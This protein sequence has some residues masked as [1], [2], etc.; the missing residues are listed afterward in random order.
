MKRIVFLI[1]AICCFSCKNVYNELIPNNEQSIVSFG[2]SSEDYQTRSIS[3]DIKHD[4]ITV[5]VPTGTD[6]TR[7]LVQ[8]KVSKQAT[9]FPLTL[10]Y[11][12]EAFPAT[13]VVQLALRMN[14]NPAAKSL[15]KW[16][17][18]LYLENPEFKIPPL[19]FPINFF[20]PVQFAV[21]G[22]QGGVEIYTVKVLYEDGSD[23][24]IPPPQEEEPQISEKKILTFNVP[25]YQKGESN[26]G[27][28]TVKFFLKPGADVRVLVPQ[29]TVS[30]NCV[31]LPLTREYLFD[32]A[33]K[34]NLDALTV[35]QGFITATDKEAFLRAT[36][37]PCDTSN[38][39]L[40]LDKPIDFTDPVQ[41]V[42]LHRGDKTVKLY[43]ITCSTDGG[44][45][46]LENIGISKFQN[47][48]VMK[49]AIGTIDEANKRIECTVYYPVE[50]VTTH[51]ESLKLNIDAGYSGDSIE[52]EY[53]GT[54]YAE[55]DAVPFEPRKIA[56]EQYS[57]G[58]AVLKV[59]ILQDS[60]KVTYTMRLTFKED[61]D[62][63]RS[64]T[65]FRF[66]KFYNEKI[67]STAVASIVNRDDEGEIRATV[68]YTG[69][70][71]PS[72]LKPSFITGGGA[73]VSVAGTPQVSKQ[74]EQNF[75]TEL[76]YLCISKDK[77][78]KRTYTVTV[79]FEKVETPEALMKSFS[80]G[81]HLNAG[82]A[83]DAI[84]TIDNTANTITV[85]VT[86]TTPIVPEELIP[87]FSSTGVVS[88]AGIMQTSGSSKHSFRYAVYYKVTSTDDPTVTKT[89]KV[90]V[91]FNYATE[92]R[93]ELLRF[94][95]TKEDNPT[96][97]ED[98]ECYIS[99]A[100][101]NVFALLPYGTDV[102]DLK[103]RFEVYGK[104]KV[105][106]TE[107]TS[108]AS[109][110]DFSQVVDYVVESE[111]GQYSKTY[112]VK[113]QVAGEIIYLSSK[114]CGRNNGTSW[115]DAFT[116]LEAAIEAANKMSASPEIWVA[117][118]GFTN[119]KICLHRAITLRGGFNGTETSKDERRRSSDG[120]LSK[121]L[122]LTNV[123]IT[124]GMWGIK[125]SGAFLFDG[126]AIHRHG[127]N[128]AGLGFLYCKWDESA[129]V[130]NSVSFIDCI[131]SDEIYLNTEIL[132]FLSV[133]NSVFTRESCIY[134]HNSFS[135]N[136]EFLVDKSE[137]LGKV[138]NSYGFGD[139]SNWGCMGKVEISNSKLDSS[140]TLYAK[141]MKFEKCNIYGANSANL[142]LCADT[143][144]CLTIN[145]SKFQSIS[146]ITCNK[147]EF[148]F[149]NS[150]LNT[151]IFRKRNLSIGFVLIS[152]VTFKNCS[153]KSV[154]G[155][156]PI[157]AKRLLISDCY[158]NK[159]A[160]FIMPA[161]NVIINRSRFAT[162]DTH[163][164]NV[165]SDI[166][167]IG[168]TV[169]R[170]TANKFFCGAISAEKKAIALNLTYNV[171]AHDYQEPIEA[172]MDGEQ[173][174]ENSTFNN[175]YCLGGKEIILKKVNIN[176][177]S[178]TNKMI[179]AP[180]FFPEYSFVILRNGR[181]K[182]S[183]IRLE[184]V[185]GGVKLQRPTDAS[186]LRCVSNNIIC[187]EASSS[188]E[189]KGVR[190]FS[191]AE[192]YGKDS[193]NV[194]RSN[195]RTV[196][197]CTTQYNDE[198]G[199]IRKKHVPLDGYSK[200]APGLLIA[201]K[202]VTFTKNTL[203]D[204]S[205]HIARCSPVRCK[206]SCEDEF[207]FRGNYPE[208]LDFMLYLPQGKT[209][210]DE[211]F[212]AVEILEQHPK[213]IPFELSKNNE[214]EVLFKNCFFTTSFVNHRP[215]VVLFAPKLQKKD[216]LRSKYLE[217][218]RSIV[219]FS[220]TLKIKSMHA[221]WHNEEGISGS[222]MVAGGIKAKI[223][224]EDSTFDNSYILG[225]KAMIYLDSQR[226][227]DTATIDSHA[228]VFSFEVKNS[229][230][231]DISTL[232]RAWD[233]N[234]L[235]DNCSFD[236][237]GTLII[238]GYRST[239][240]AKNKSRFYLNSR[241]LKQDIA[242]YLEL[243]ELDMDDCEVVASSASYTTRETLVKANIAKISNS[244]FLKTDYLCDVTLDV[245]RIAFITDSEFTDVGWL[246][247]LTH[248]GNSKD[249][250]E[251][252]LRKNIIKNAKLYLQLYDIHAKESNGFASD[253][254]VLF[255]DCDIFYENTIIIPDNNK[256]HWKESTKRYEAVLEG[257][258]PFKF[259]YNLANLPSSLKA[260]LPA[261]MV[262]SGSSATTMIGGIIRERFQ[263]LVTR[264]I[265][266]FFNLEG[267]PRD[268]SPQKFYGNYN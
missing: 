157:I 228:K 241:I 131:I 149:D 77:H 61:P 7:L 219:A 237:I 179:E 264:R 184:E 65:D 116:T 6:V 247:F 254:S 240:V 63:I 60:Q 117:D 119:E 96:L 225:E 73:T 175:L 257:P 265:G 103:P 208:M 168:T 154:G 172:E 33:D 198:Y 238:D 28:D 85:K 45:P 258:I 248:W 209:F 147:T 41:F 127:H 99:M 58:E 216:T 204:V 166:K 152:S 13:D 112:K 59:H 173:R 146:I 259:K 150:E 239:L 222:M 71:K 42:V 169:D 55:Y 27:D 26:I 53:K 174:I 97:R 268:E 102:S 224:I 171:S 34:L 20:S 72:E 195:F 197:S 101:Y 234:M 80:F 88:V 153:M 255:E 108:G 145:K 207:N 180:L 49:D 8:A 155:V 70:A 245:S 54:A 39:T 163:C 32:L 91:E 31:A 142:V 57:L 92:S 266:Y 1:F 68:L 15:D 256:I 194:Q 231:T 104:V 262:P 18:D 123:G 141:N 133:K 170:L 128:L 24:A 140:V 244:K 76:N 79:K 82:L 230:F 132:S 83:G 4:Y 11:L 137:L 10:R 206:I 3:T 69:D 144:G 162:I 233:C 205:D 118:E 90:N 160:E 186:W 213:E 159:N 23:P 250:D 214:G 130:D 203:T 81:M 94:Y 135:N 122:N 126:I 242:P 138:E 95:F 50:W 192:F 16:F 115:E 167:T 246:K 148:K 121:V 220:N 178:N 78:Y 164:Q 182:N 221:C 188:Q 139:V 17:L 109:S 48:Q 62:T 181:T 5:K 44:V 86:H 223:E 260:K 183:E 36:L 98:V 261:G 212:V 47:P 177:A 217:D 143:E 129:S 66:E 93:C 151:I 156:V 84:G 114:A 191:R 100:S 215:N 200:K 67:K 185:D 158:D 227:K 226:E 211:Q 201:G 229:R 218:T 35:A 64:I 199:F 89:Y 176:P 46:H 134:F 9:L 236:H 51:P 161:T 253:S 202:K 40:D 113:L 111:D 165:P 232:I 196:Q 43:T 19:V 107:Q 75:S 193:V 74:S 110:Q 267:E 106:G 251:I 37:S 25:L 52:F 29:V 263:G 136:F 189:D 22:G 30:P 125:T 120:K 21:I 56:N 87:E 2:L 187:G 14:I 249:Y 190:G 38:L 12:Q 105:G 210:T 235:F 243:E 124:A 252:V